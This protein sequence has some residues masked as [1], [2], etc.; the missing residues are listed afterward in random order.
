MSVPVISTISELL[1][2]T[3]DVAMVPWHP[4]ASG[5][6]TSWSCSGLPTGVSINTGTGVISGTPTTADQYSCS[7]VATNGDGSS[8]PFEFVVNVSASGLADEGMVDLTIGLD[9]GL[10]NGMAMGDDALPLLYATPADVIGLAIGFERDGVLRALAPTKITIAM[11]DTYGLP[12]VTV[13]DAAPGAPLDALEPRYRALFTLTAAEIADMLEPHAK[14]GS[15][16]GTDFNM[17]AK[18]QITFEFS[19]AAVDGE[20]DRARTSVEFKVHLAKRVSAE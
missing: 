3:E 13:Y 7:L 17:R 12:P 16:G 10:V 2:L 11:R 20:T 9:T 1:D 8:A 19:A 18:C 6:P 14:D 15:R 4:V 5:T